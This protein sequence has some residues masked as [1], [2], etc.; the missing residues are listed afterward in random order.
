[1]TKDERI[2]ELE[3]EVEILRQQLTEK[4]KKIKQINST[5][6]GFQKAIEKRDKQIAGL[7]KGLAKTQSNSYKI[8]QSKVDDIITIA[9][10]TE[11]EREIRHAICEKIRNK[12]EV[13]EWYDAESVYYEIR[14]LL[15]KIE[16]GEE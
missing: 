15:H 4:E 9:Q 11:K 5:V 3:R 14:E 16:Q 12:L 6:T 13:I 10:L 8:K 2:A 7:N 1:M